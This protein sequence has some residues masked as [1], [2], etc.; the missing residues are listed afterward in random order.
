MCTPCGVD[1]DSLVITM[2]C[3]ALDG[4]GIE[5]HR[6]ANLPQLFRLAQG[7]T[8]LIILWVLGLFPGGKAAKA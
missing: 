1:R 5:S 8:S 2:I 6:G 3:Y 7:P 4:P